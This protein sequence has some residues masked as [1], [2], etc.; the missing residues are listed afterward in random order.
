MVPREAL[1]A[2][3]GNYDEELVAEDFMADSERFP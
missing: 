2:E 1:L 3:L